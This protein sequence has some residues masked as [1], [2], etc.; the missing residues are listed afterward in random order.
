MG[1]SDDLSMVFSM[2]RGYPPTHPGEHPSVASHRG[3]SSIPGPR[4]ARPP[5]ASWPSGPALGTGAAGR[6]QKP[7][8]FNITHSAFNL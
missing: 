4:C 1:G 2:T 8:V 7:Y 6:G 3:R 5:P